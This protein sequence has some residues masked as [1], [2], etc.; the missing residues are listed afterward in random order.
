M[1]IRSRI[2]ALLVTLA[3]AVAALA[4]AAFACSPNVGG[5]IC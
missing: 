4:P 5:G 3:V 1:S 2:A